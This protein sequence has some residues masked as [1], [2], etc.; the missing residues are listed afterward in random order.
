MQPPLGR[1]AYLY[2]GTAAFERDRAYYRD[3]LGAELVWAFHAFGARVA[4]FR[5]CQG[6]LVLLADH[7]PA[8]S[9]TPVLAGLGTSLAV[10]T[11]RRKLRGR[12]AEP[13]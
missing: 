8:P 13:A 1:L 4:A 3:V 2:V 11:S 10:L 12:A 9:C 5:V 7:R 6:P